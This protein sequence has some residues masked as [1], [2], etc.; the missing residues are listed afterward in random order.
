M[1]DEQFI[2]GDVPMTKSEVRAVSISKL[3]LKPDSVL[4]D[5]GAGTGSVSI[6][7]SRFLTGGRV[8][9]IER[10]A[11]AISL[12]RANKDKFRADCLEIV[13]GAAPEAMTGLEAPTHVFIGG[14]SGSMEAVLA[15]VLQKNPKAR[16]VM[17]VIALESLGAV[18]TWLK[19][20]SVTAEIVQ[21][22]VSKG[23]LAGD[24]HLMLGQNPVYVVSFGG[25]GGTVFE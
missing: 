23:R 3:E 22:Q 17:N 18:L 16:I 12:I 21:V 7:A 24:C 19:K 4:Y 11:E 25:E 2:R 1:R 5:V 14:T 8:Y 10:K 20:H 6:E 15:L 13:E 9:A